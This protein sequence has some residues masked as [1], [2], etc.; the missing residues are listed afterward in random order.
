MPRTPIGP[1]VSPSQFVRTKPMISPALRVATVKN[2][3]TSRIAGNA[4]RPAA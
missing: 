1:F 4:I 3:R 2:T